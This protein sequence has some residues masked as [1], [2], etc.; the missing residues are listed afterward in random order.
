MIGQSKPQVLT[1]V[2]AS[3]GIYK[4]RRMNLEDSN[5][6]RLS[7]MIHSNIQDT[8]IQDFKVARAD[9]AKQQLVMGIKEFEI[10]IFCLPQ[11]MLRLLTRNESKV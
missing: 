11:I 8:N 4:I 1:D 9:G 5:V 6:F 2:G 7:G 10:P 3:G